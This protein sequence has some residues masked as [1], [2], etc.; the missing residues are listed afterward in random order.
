MAYAVLVLS[1][2]SSVL[3]LCFSPVPHLLL[4]G[5]ENLFQAAAD[6]IV[7][8]LGFQAWEIKES[9]RTD[10]HHPKLKIIEN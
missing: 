1:P 3:R 6:L 2:R 7:L 9:L 10:L 5:R 4:E 8:V